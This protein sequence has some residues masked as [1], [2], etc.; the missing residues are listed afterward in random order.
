MN[1]SYQHLELSAAAQQLVP[2]AG[3][4]LRLKGRLPLRP[5]G[6]GAKGE[7]Y[8]WDEQHQ[9]LWDRILQD[10]VDE[11]KAWSS[12]IGIAKSVVMLEE[13]SSSRTPKDKMSMVIPIDERNSK[14]AIRNAE[15][16][17]F[18]DLDWRPYVLHQEV[19]IR[20]TKGNIVFVL[21]LL[22]RETKNGTSAVV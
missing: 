18:R 10:Y 20:A 1:D 5:D 13:G 11:L 16:E 2:E 15:G 9:Q 22:S 7:E 4:H 14:I 3:C 6:S 8:A 21:I 17:I 12:D 19:S